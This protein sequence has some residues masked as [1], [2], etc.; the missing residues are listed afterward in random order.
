MRKYLVLSI[1][2]LL[3]SSWLILSGKRA[4]AQNPAQASTPQTETRGDASRSVNSAAP[5]TITSLPMSK[6]YCYQPNPA[7][8]QCVVNV[9]YW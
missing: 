6:P 9:R 4:A 7:V 5:D 3:L 1:V 8:D 2:I